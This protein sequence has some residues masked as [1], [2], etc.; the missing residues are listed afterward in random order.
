MRLEAPGPQ[1]KASIATAGLAS[2]AAGWPRAQSSSLHNR[3]QSSGLHRIIRPRLARPGGCVMA[4]A[5][6]GPAEAAK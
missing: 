3:G 5:E 6:D 1:H 2:R 4:R